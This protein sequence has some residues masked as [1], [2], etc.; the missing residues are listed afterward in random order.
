M[1]LRALP[2]F[3]PRRE[4]RENFEFVFQAVKLQEYASLASEAIYL[5]YTPVTCY[6]WL[7]RNTDSYYRQGCTQI[8]RAFFQ[9][10]MPERLLQ[11]PPSY[12]K[13]KKVTESIKLKIEF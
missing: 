4:L 12:L 8:A 11:E 2:E 10:K 7:G 1:H 9:K 13:A 5:L 6:L 3:Q